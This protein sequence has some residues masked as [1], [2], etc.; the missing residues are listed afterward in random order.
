[1]DGRGTAIERTA[2]RDG[3]ALEPILNEC[4]RPRIARNCAAGTGLSGV[5]FRRPLSLYKQTVVALRCSF[6]SDVNAERI[7][8]S[9]FSGA[10]GQTP[11]AWWL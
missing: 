8:N 5:S 6:L 4:V 11:H 10:F 9:E 3:V 1:M 7:T 2:W